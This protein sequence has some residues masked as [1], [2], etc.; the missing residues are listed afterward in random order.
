MKYI[1]QRVV[2]VVALGL[3]IISLQSCSPKP[4]A[5]YCNAVAELSKGYVSD[6]DYG[7]SY[8]KTVETIDEAIE[9]ANLSTYEERNFSRD[10]HEAA[11]IAYIESPKIG[12]TEIYDRMHSKCMS[13]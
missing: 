6:R 7:W 3:V 4:T 9:Q 2:G 8:K 1:L 10:L 12:R 5:K 13:R 11:E